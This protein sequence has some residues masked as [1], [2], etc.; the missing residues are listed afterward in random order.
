[1]EQ[2]GKI[3]IEE[4]QWQNFYTKGKTIPP[5]VPEGM[6]SDELQTFAHLV[7]FLKS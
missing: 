4:L 2:Q 7:P 6:T 3:N 5:F 1:L